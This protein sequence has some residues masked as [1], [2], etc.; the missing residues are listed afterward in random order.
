MNDAGRAL[1]IEEI[2]MI[3]PP[4]GIAFAACLIV[5]AVPTTLTPKGPAQ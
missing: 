1:A 4:A 3:D 2:A 5:W